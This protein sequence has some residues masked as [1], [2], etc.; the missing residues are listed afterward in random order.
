MDTDKLLIVEVPMSGAAYAKPQQR[1]VFLRRIIEE[2]EATPGV[3]AVSGVSILPIDKGWPYPYSRSDRP[4][5][6]PN[7]MPRAGLRSVAAGYHKTYGIPVLRGRAIDSYDTW[8]SERVMMVNK[9]FAETAFAGEEVLGK[10]INH[11]GRPWRIVGVF[12]DTKNAGLARKTEP[13]VNM[14]YY[15]WEGADALSVFFTVRAVSN[16]QALAPIVTEKVRKLNPDQPLSQFRV[17]QAYLDG[18]TA[19][20]RFRSMLIAMFALAALI[21]ASVGIYGVVAYSVTQRTNEMGIRMALGAQRSDLLL[22]ILRQ[23]LQLTL[24]GVTLGLLG[25][26][27]LARVL[28]SYLFGI[29]A[30][31]GKTYLTIA[32][33]LSFVGL[34]ACLVPAIRATLVNPLNALRNE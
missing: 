10:R 26:L 14:P 8:A 1:V 3:E 11:F 20:D 2:M 21:L 12:A 19:M 34:L 31:D 27:A 22:M 18:R 16:P 32:T 6:P 30:T 23:G 9:T 7:K 13:E 5:P 25:S 15:Q 24:S 17:L 28:E 29:A 4:V 33:V